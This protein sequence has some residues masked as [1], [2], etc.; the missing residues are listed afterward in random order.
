MEL[1]LSVEEQELLL[2]ILEERHSELLK[3][4]WHTDKHEFKKLLRRK[5]EL[6]ESLV[7]R[8]KGTAAQEVR[9]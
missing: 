1:T 6:L 8:L 7:C 5:E 3:E 4:I 2:N 9:G